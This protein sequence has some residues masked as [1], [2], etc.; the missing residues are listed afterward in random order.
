MRSFGNYLT[1]GRVQAIGA[2]SALTVLSWYVTPLAFLLS[3]TPV[4]LVTLRRGA[5]PGIQV[6]TGCFLVIGLLALLAHIDPMIA[7]VFALGVWA[8]VWLLALVLRWTEAQGMLVLAAGVMGMLFVAGMRLALNDVTAWWQSGLDAW[9]KSAVPP[10]LAQQYQQV[11]HQAAPMMN[12]MVGGM[13]VATLVT[14][15]LLGRAWQASLFNPGGFR[16]EFYRLRLPRWLVLPAVLLVAA[17]I[18]VHGPFRPMLRDLVMVILFMYMF[19][20]FSTIHRT[21][22]GKRLSRAWLIIMYGMLLLLPDM[23]LFVAC[24]GLA[25]SMLG[26]LMR[27]DSGS[28]AS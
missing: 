27:P 25:D 6:V 12:A 15:L 19:Q 26:A 28:D 5:V 24:V 18:V 8:P 10:D 11:L 20:G 23:I 16:A 13:L 7:G 22:S 2:I 14:T 21:V 3:G 9:L 1:R 4:A 17:V